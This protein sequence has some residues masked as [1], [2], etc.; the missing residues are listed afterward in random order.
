MILLRQCS[1]HPWCAEGIFVQVFHVTCVRI[2]SLLDMQSDLYCMAMLCPELNRT[3]STVLK[4]RIVKS[5]FHSARWSEQSSQ[6]EPNHQFWQVNDELCRSVL[7]TLVYP[8]LVVIGRVACWRRSRSD[9]FRWPFCVRSEFWNEDWTKISE[10]TG[11][12]QD[13]NTD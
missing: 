11:T 7:M 1:N 8:H 6:K 10:L 4:M 3:G 12:E 9:A 2:Y 5:H 13:L